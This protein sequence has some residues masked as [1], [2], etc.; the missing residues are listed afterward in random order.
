MPQLVE[1]YFREKDES[2]L[3]LLRMALRLGKTNREAAIYAQGLVVGKSDREIQNK[4]LIFLAAM[5]SP[6]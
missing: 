5:R 4:L 6:N 2:R 3:S 1:A